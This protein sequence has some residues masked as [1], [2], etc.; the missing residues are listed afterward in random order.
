VVASRRDIGAG[1]W[2]GR[3]T[4]VAQTALMRSTPGFA[5][6]LMRGTAVAWAVGVGIF[7]GVFGIVSTAVSDAFKENSSVSD[8]FSR[9]GAE[10]SAPGYVGVTFVMLSA[11]L[12]IA[13]ANFLGASRAEEADGRLEYVTALPVRRSD[14]LLTRTALAAASIVVIG[15]V[16]GVGGWVGVAVSGGDIAF[17]RMFLAGV[18]VIA[19]GLVVLG[20]GTLAYGSFARAGTAVA[21]AL[22]AWSVLVELI[23]AFANFNHFILDTSIIH[24]VAAAPAMDPH[25]DA[26]AVM[27]VIAVLAAIGGAVGLQRRDLQPG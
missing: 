12:G 25:W 2:P 23:G 17:G 16:A 20:V 5:L 14:W 13:A 27:L 7:A 3:D 8:I 9:L 6:R 19:P 21:Y 24:H 18:N 10:L 26:T 22:V 15:L 1:Q 4:A 11:A